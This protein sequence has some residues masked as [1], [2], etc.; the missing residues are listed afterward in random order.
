MLIS[1]PNEKSGGSPTHSRTTHVA[2]MNKT[3]TGVC[4]KHEIQS[5]N[6]VGRVGVWGG[7][8]LGLWLGG[9]GQETRR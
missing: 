9:G 3:K 7:G 5:T 2:V 8:G 1:F 4:L 6:D